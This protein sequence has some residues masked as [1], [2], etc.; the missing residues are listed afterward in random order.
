M[1]I[2]G[3]NN[4]TPLKISK[5]EGV[6]PQD[7]R[8]MVDNFMGHSLTMLHALSTQHQDTVANDESTK[9]KIQKIVDKTKDEIEGLKKIFDPLIKSDKSLSKS[10]ISQAKSLMKSA[11]KKMSKIL[12]K[13][14]DQ[15]ALALAG[16]DR[17]NIK[18]TSPNELTGSQKNF[19]GDIKA[20]AQD[21]KTWWVS[22]KA[23][24]GDN[25]SILALKTFK[26]MQEASNKPFTA[27]IPKTEVDKDKIAL[28]NSRSSSLPKGTSASERATKK[29]Q[30][31]EL[32]KRAQVVGLNGIYRI[33]VSFD[34]DQI[35]KQF[36]SLRAQHQ[37]DQE[38]GVITSTMSLLDNNG[39]SVQISSQLVPL[40]NEFD[41]Q[42]KERNSRID[43]HAFG[44]IV[45]SKGI[46]SFERQGTH[47]VNA[48]DS[49]L[50]SADGTLIY[51]V[52]RHGALST[53]KKVASTS[54]ETRVKTADTAAKELITAAL[55]NQ[56]ADSGKSIEEYLDQFKDGVPLA[57]NSLS[58]LTPVARPA[59]FLGRTTPERMLLQDQL[60]AFERLKKEGA[61][62][63]IGN[64]EVKLQV[65]I[66]SFNF[67]VNVGAVKLTAGTLKQHDLNLKALTGTGLGLFSQSEEITPDS[68]MGQFLG[69]YK[70][71]SEKQNHLE[72]K[73]VK[74]KGKRDS[75][76]PKLE[77]N[78]SEIAKL[79]ALIELD[80]DTDQN[81]Q[82]LDA[83]VLIR[84]KLTSTYTKLLT[85]IKQLE[86]T[87]EKLSPIK[88]KKEMNNLME[89]ITK[90]MKTDTAYLEGGNQYG[91]AAR[92]IALSNLINEIYKTAGQSGPHMTFNCMSNK[93]RSGVMDCVGKTFS[94]MYSTNGTFPTREQLDFKNLKKREQDL[95]KLRKEYDEFKNNPNFYK[96]YKKN[97]AEAR[98][99]YQKFLDNP[100]VKQLTAEIAQ[101]T[102]IQKQFAANL[103]KM[104]LESGSLELIETNTGVKGYK[105]GNE[106]NLS[107][108]KHLVNEF[109]FLK[110]QGLGA[111][112]E[113]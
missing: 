50:K 36:I 33:G 26:S 96:D 13:A 97:N 76:A 43:T 38:R 77:Q 32:A 82:K 8:S 91:L 84:N 1:N 59:T 22:I 98:R 44:D 107:I 92:I 6:A 61:T 78:K 102:S 42:L 68:F 113:S 58:L 9:N 112:T 41:K 57:L 62:I 94:A 93:D 71:L 88:L 79:K 65:K 34:K 66:N 5:T 45:G 105:V 53:G 64:R 101:I 80:I 55:L 86:L 56:I 106:A 25:A 2:E 35:R 47:L 37:S 14:Q 70:I 89:Q 19:L 20:L 67:G 104:L 3:M 81:K 49:R 16:L 90:M 10:D 110:I 69:A 95:A 18:S 75:L 83:L 31:E 28:Q 99:L 40:N 100:Q 72:V 39:G 21:K 29:L 27:T 48:Y 103:Y 87:L 85:N 46:S 111:I 30:K 73:L 7:A 24:F 52:I 4:P 74:E 109:S 15:F 51:Q 17:G 63:K 11:E 108:F 23:T 54:H 12:A 60:D